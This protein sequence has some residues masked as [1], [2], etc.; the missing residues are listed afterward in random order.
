M[1][2]CNWSERIIFKDN[3]EW[4]VYL[5]YCQR[6]KTR[7]FIQ[8]CF[9][10]FMK[11]NITF[12]NTWVEKLKKTFISIQIL[13]RNKI[14]F[15]ANQMNKSRAHIEFV[16]FYMG[17]AY[18]HLV[19]IKLYV[20]YQNVS[21][22]FLC[23]VFVVKCI[24]CQY[25][26][27][28]QKDFIF[29]NYYCNYDKEE[30]SGRLEWYI[31]F[32]SDFDKLSFHLFYQRNFYKWLEIRQAKN[33]HFKTKIASTSTRKSFWVNVEKNGDSSSQGLSQ[34]ILWAIRVM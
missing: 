29:L 30:D 1:L 22:Y 16:E 9:S 28:K 20:E 34:D 14:Q 25:L 26:M 17:P 23:S 15:N 3:S 18:I 19:C 12:K 10:S 27:Q 32:F 31:L 24:S 6:M 7:K 33:Y 8:F 11:M 21:D 5:M 2:L 13:L 4:N